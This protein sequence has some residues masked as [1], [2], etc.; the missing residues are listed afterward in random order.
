VLDKLA[1]IQERMV[2]D[3]VVKKLQGKQMRRVLMFYIDI[4]LAGLRKSIQYFRTPY[5]QVELRTSKKEVGHLGTEP[6][7]PFSGFTQV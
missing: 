6:A 3:D 2:I 5:K 4:L 1:S 7:W